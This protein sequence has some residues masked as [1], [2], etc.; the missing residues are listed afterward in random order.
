MI[1][2][3]FFDHDRDHDADARV[4]GE[5]QVPT[6][7][8]TREDLRGANAVF[9][10][11]GAPTT[12]GDGGAQR[13]HDHDNQAT[14]GAHDVIQILHE[15]YCRAL[16]D[17]QA[18]LAGNWTTPVAGES[19][20]DTQEDHPLRR[21]PSA[22]RESTDGGSIEALLSGVRVL[23]D[24]FGSLGEGGMPGLAGLADTEPIPEILRLFAPAEYHAAV[25]RRPA[26]LP[27]ALAR[28]EHHTLGI[29]SPMPAPDTTA[30]HDIL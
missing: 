14:T 20:M 26:T 7:Y 24:V 12:D 11:I 18:S 16:D 25:S 19:S 21:E 4:D 5:A 30:R 8:D 22:G 3:G 23:S 17:P 15:Q 28:R 2:A 27:P 9:G 13:T 6:V 10:L 29:D 1:D